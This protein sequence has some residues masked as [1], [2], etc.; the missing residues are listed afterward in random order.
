MATNIREV[1]RV[2]RHRRIRKEMV[3]T[4]ERPRLCI[5]RSLKNM[6]ASLIDDVARKTLMGMSTLDKGVRKD[7]PKGGNIKAAE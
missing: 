3:G 6:S 2:Y 5:H 1:K 4:P 7:S